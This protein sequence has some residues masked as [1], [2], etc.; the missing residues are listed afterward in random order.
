M[1]TAYLLTFLFI[2][3]LTIGIYL[4]GYAARQASIIHVTALEIFWGLL[5]I[6]PILIFVEKLNFLELFTKPNEESW[7]WLGSAAAFGVIGGNY[8]SL[9]NLKLS[10]ERTNSLLSPSI[11]AC[12]IVSSVL[13]LNENI[14]ITKLLGLLVTL[15]SVLFFVILQTKKNNVIKNSLRQIG[16]S[17]A[18]ILCITL[19]IIFSIKGT[20]YSQLSIMHSIWLRLIIAL[21]FMLILLFITKKKIVTKGSAKYFFAII[22][23]VVAQTIVASYLWFYC[24]Y[25]IGISS[26]QI[27]ISTL[28]FFVYTVDVYIFKKTKPSLYFLL[29][30]ILALIGIWIVVHG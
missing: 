26:F 9:L 8:F 27:I 30:A 6:G 13:F 1:L 21:P 20:M 29:T 23:G 4:F 3:S 11:T 5:L 7:L 24:T 22:G 10:G 19:S 17:I 14:T 16:A 25:K 15:G 2:V 18:T 12:T 28:P